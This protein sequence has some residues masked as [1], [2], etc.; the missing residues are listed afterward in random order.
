MDA[1][2]ERV[3]KSIGSKAG[4]EKCGP[5]QRRHTFASQLL[6]KGADLP[7]VASIMGHSD[8]EVIKNTMVVLS[9]PTIAVT[10]RLC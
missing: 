5:N 9:V 7:F 2:R 6:T 4:I 1:R 8:M 10:L 3:F